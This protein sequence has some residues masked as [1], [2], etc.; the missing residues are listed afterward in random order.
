MNAKQV[1]QAALGELQLEI[2]KPS[3]DACMKHARL[4]STHDN[5]YVIAVPSTFVKEWV[6]ER[7]LRQIKR[8][9][10]SI[11][12]QEAEVD[13]VVSEVT[14]RR[15]G[16]EVAASALGIEEQ[17]GNGAGE[18]APALNLELLEVAETY[19][20]NGWKPNPKYTFAA[21]I[22][23]SSN[24]LVH[25]AACAVAE[26][27]AAAYNP[28]FIY[29]GVGLGKTHLLHAIAHDAIKRKYRALYVPS[30]TFTNDLVNAI[31]E[32]RTEEFRNRYRSIDVLLI[33]DIQFIAGKESTQEEFFHTFNTLH[34][35]NKQIVVSSDRHPK[36]IV[37]LEERLRSRFLWGLIA[38]I[39]PP[40][41]E[42]RMAILRAK[43]DSM[44]IGTPPDVLEYVARKVQSNIRELEGCLNRIVAYAGLRNRQLCLAVA[45]EALSDILE[46]QARRYITPAKVVEA[47]ARY[48]QVDPRAMRGKHRARQIVIPRQV[49]M[50]LMREETDSSLLEIGRELG[51]RDHT[52]IIHGHEKIQSEI[53]VNGELRGQVLAIKEALYNNVKRA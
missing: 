37:T 51:G 38:D 53:D 47:V 7:L 13:V 24:R 15:K 52:T 6:E 2:P 25:A 36:S 33:D 19:P 30:E 45:T 41:F 40:D 18:P 39:Q 32:R 22:V 49:A 35:A 50:Y 20:N 34:G 9:L 1:W 43:A 23:G 14:Q 26:K 42:T 17:Q 44:G 28:L 11:V 21:F 46:N 10:S 4:V 5:T 29:G 12:G 3:Y 48:Y 8:T 31:R 27:P 16:L